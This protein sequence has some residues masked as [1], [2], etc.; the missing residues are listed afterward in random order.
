MANADRF[1]VLR[2][3]DPQTRREVF[4]FAMKRSEQILRGQKDPPASTEPYAVS[5]PT[6]TEQ[7]PKS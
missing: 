6:P 1:K 2:Q 5:D 4:E 3:L 7:T